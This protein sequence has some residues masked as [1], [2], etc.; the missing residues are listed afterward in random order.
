M[1]TDETQKTPTCFADLE[2]VFPLRSDGLRVTPIACLQC[3]HKTPCLR[4]ALGKGRGYSVREEMVDRA[5]RGGV[6]GF[7]QRWSQKKSIHRLKQ[8]SVNGD[9][10]TKLTN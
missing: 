2:T 5:Y 9:R 7:F 4:A 6:I 10:C 1:K 8:K 3:V